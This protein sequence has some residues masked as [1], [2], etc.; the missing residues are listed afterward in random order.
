MCL[1]FHITSQVSSFSLTKPNFWHTC[2][3]E[4]CSSDSSPSLSLNNSPLFPQYWGQSNQACCSG[5]SVLCAKAAQSGE[6]F[7]GCLELSGK[8][9]AVKLQWSGSSVEL[10]Q[11]WTTRVCA[12]RLD[13]AAGE[14]L[15][16]APVRR[17]V[18]HFDRDAVL[19]TV[20]TSFQHVLSFSLSFPHPAQ[21]GAYPLGL[22][23][24]GTF[25]F[26]LRP[27]GS[28][29]SSRTHHREGLSEPLE[30]VLRGGSWGGYSLQTTPSK[31]S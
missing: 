29:Q 15:C 31:G 22:F 20:T 12:N 21:C 11:L 7:Q 17:M 9:K 23:S 19:P 13:G 10:R 6:S 27:R 2:Q 18:R 4:C 5:Y 24:P 16:L 8:R 1:M 28:S 25:S 26:W 30:R 3:V 14:Q